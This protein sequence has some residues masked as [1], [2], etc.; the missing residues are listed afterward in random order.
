MLR[1]R[2]RYY[3][4]KNMSTTEHDELM[5]LGL[6]KSVRL[7]GSYKNVHNMYVLYNFLGSYIM[8]LNV[9]TYFETQN[10]LKWDMYNLPREMR[11]A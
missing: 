4:K 8:T 1:S 5:T 9:H 6:P 7:F 2:C 3:F 10:Y 11:V